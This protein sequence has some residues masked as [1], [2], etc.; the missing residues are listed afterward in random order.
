ME[1]K[2]VPLQIKKLEDSGEFVGL[3]STY[4]NVDLG[5]DVI[6]RGAFTNTI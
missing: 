4:G 5:G 2:A 1:H 6:E 3:A